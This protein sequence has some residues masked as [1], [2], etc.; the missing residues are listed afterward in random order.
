MKT[1]AD[2]PPP[3]KADE[4][5]KLIGLGKRSISK[6]YYPE[7]KNRLDELEHFRAL[8]DRVS[9]AII[10]VDADTGIILDATGSTEAMLGCD[11]KALQ[12]TSFQSLLPDHI[13]RYSQNLF[14][15]RNENMSLETEFCSPHSKGASCVPVE[16]TL[17]IVE[18]SGKNR[19]VIV[20]RDISERKR[21]EETLRKSHAELEIHVRERTRELDRANRAKTEFLSIVSHELRTPLTSVLGFAKI[22]RKKL[23]EVVYPAVKHN[24][25]PKLCNEMGRIRKNLDIIVSEGERLTALINDVLDLAKMEANKV[26]Y[27]MEALSPN[28]FIGQSINATN[29][30]FI[31]SGLALHTDIQPN[32]P[33]VMADSDRLIQV[34]VNLISNGVKFTENGTITIRARQ[35]GEHIRVS[36]TDTGLGIPKTM[37]DTI[38]DE[39]TQGQESLADRP[40]GTGLGL[41][42][43]RNIIE[44]HQGHLWVESSPGKGSKFIF[45]LPLH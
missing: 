44:G 16:M 28:E 7:L 8:L 31:D 30:L 29:A 26:E 11:A 22:I 9:D 12:G 17:R 33:S 5:E 45:T 36:I 38:F 21:S 24:K 15:S 10:V 27:R 14:N 32:M 42:I 13:A 6:S 37:C 2:P 23:L 41:P 18:Y 4:R 40:K 25:E 34:M 43:S 3:K 20:A 19:G 39:F 1:Q 35:V